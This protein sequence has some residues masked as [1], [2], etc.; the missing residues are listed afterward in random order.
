[1]ATRM[2]IRVGRQTVR[3]PF[4]NHLPRLL[5]AEVPRAEDGEQPAGP[6]PRGVEDSGVPAGRGQGGIVSAGERRNRVAEV[7]ASIEPEDGKTKEHVGSCRKDRIDDHVE[8]W[9]VIDAEVVGQLPGRAPV[10]ANVDICSKVPVVP[11]E[12]EVLWASVRFE[13]AVREGGAVGAVH[14][15]V[16]RHT[17]VGGASHTKGMTGGVGD[18]DEAPAGGVD[19]DVLHCRIRRKPLGSIGPGSAAIAGVPEALSRRRDDDVLVSG[20]GHGEGQRVDR[21]EHFLPP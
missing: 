8:R 18:G 21:S 9:V 11:G 13:C 3:D 5:V 4:A 7:L 2:G 16:P 17:E 1:M 19:E 12:P 6:E 14:P 20:S 15:E 10:L